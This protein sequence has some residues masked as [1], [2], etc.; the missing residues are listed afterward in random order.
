VDKRQG[1]R[2]NIWYNGRYIRDCETREERPKKNK[3][4]R[5]IEVQRQG[6][7]DVFDGERQEIRVKK[8]ERTKVEIRKTKHGEWETREE[9]RK[10]RAGGRG[11]GSGIYFDEVERQEMIVHTVLSRPKTNERQDMREGQEG[12]RVQSLNV[13]CF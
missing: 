12:V 8:K 7:R 6:T 9:L 4:R 1:T 5:G 11:K 10:T 13:F 3:E 2:D